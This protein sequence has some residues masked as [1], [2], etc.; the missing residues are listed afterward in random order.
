MLKSILYWASDRR[1]F[2]RQLLT[3]HGE[4]ELRLVSRL[5]DPKR[6]A[7]DVGA[8]IGVYCF[9]MS[10]FTKQVVAFEPN[11]AFHNKLN[12]QARYIA[13]ERVALSN[14]EGHAE[15]QIPMGDG[16]PAGGWGT[17][18]S[19][20][21]EIADKFMVPMRTLDSYDL[22]VGFLKIDVEGHEHAVLEGAIVT[23]KK[24]RPN[25]LVEC[26]D[27][28]R[29]GATAKLF[30]FLTNLDYVGYFFEHGK[31]CGVESFELSKHQP[32]HNLKPGQRML[33]QEMNYVNN[34]VFVPK[35]NSVLF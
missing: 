23:L 21:N 6:V 13:I 34:F 22:D 8:N 10:R 26:E 18:E 4:W 17:L 1:N 20:S 32:Q 9:H 24:S 33:R 16:K 27:H 30:Q 15:L 12:R 35:N 25:I 29:S 28:H 3:K 11:P 14:R 31:A 5:V 2:Y 19:T 7:V